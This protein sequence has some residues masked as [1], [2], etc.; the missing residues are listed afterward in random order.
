M[1]VYHGDVYCLGNVI[2]LKKK[3]FNFYVQN[4]ES[5]TKNHNAYI[6]C[7]YN[8]ELPIGDKARIILYDDRG[9]QKIVKIPFSKDV[10]D[11]LVFNL[12][13][14]FKKMNL[15]HK[16]Y[17]YPRKDCYGN[18]WNTASFIA[19]YCKNGTLIW[20]SY[21][22]GDY[23]EYSLL[24]EYRKRKL[25]IEGKPVKKISIDRALRDMNT[26][27]IKKW[28]EDS[29]QESKQFSYKEF[30]IIFDSL[31]IEKRNYFF[32]IEF[33]DGTCISSSKINWN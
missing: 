25:F 27:Y 8:R 9:K 29:F 23:E 18:S 28:F 30:G 6:K 17:K 5:N 21:T 16:V 7:G 11:R 14:Y 2:K 3:G 15:P 4:T 19:T 33:F 12:P 31:E 10:T 1:R 24:A 32:K 26:K 22:C 13:E 20:N